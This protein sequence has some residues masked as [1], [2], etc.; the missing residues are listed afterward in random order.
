MKIRSEIN[1][2]DMKE[3]ITNINKTKSLSFEKINKLEK[4]LARPIKKNRKKTQIN[5]I[6]YKKE[7]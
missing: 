3:K 1:E 6:R 5:R 7:K 4:P 2:K